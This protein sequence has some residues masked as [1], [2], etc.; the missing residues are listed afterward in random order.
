MS[1]RCN[2]RIKWWIGI[3]LILTMV[4]IMLPHKKKNII[5]TEVH[6]MG[7]D[8]CGLGN[9][10]CQLATGIHYAKKYNYTVVINSASDG[11]LW[12]TSNFH[13][14][15]TEKD[16]HHKPK[17]YTETLFS[18]LPHRRL[19]FM[20]E[21]FVERLGYE[22]EGPVWVPKQT[23]RILQLEG[24]CQNKDLYEDIIPYLPMY[25]TLDDKDHQR[26]LWEKYGLHRKQRKNVMVSLRIGLDFAHMTKVNYE[27][28]RKA[29]MVATK[30]KKHGYRLVV[31]SDTDEI[32]DEW[33][34]VLDGFPRVVV[35]E[36]DITQ[37]YAGLCCEDIILGESTYHYWI[38]LCRTSLYPKHT[39]VFLFKNTDLTNRN[40]SLDTWVKLDLVNQVSL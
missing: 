28:M 15:R 37:F 23:S 1:R 18:K 7:L 38:A 16:E 21:P 31:I 22:Y 5:R 33:N 17:P 3:F 13:R 12:G 11:I 10:L 20:N 25:L 34:K 26:H 8:G 35:V 4:I 39:N 19:E 2:S 30:G 36:D 29:I 40:L 27:C 24:L 32:G 9:N 6:I 14:D